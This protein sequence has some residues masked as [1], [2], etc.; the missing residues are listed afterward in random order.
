MGMFD[1]IILKEPIP[2][3]VTGCSGLHTSIQTKDFACQGDVWEIGD[4]IDTD[5]C[6]SIT[7][8]WAWDFGSCKDFDN[9]KLILYY[10][11]ENKILVGVYT[12]LMDI[13]SFLRYPIDSYHMDV[14]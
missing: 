11:V 10:V 6:N 14:N 13:K 3:I 1:T 4:I 5:H 12:T 8:D 7:E 2:C 9:S